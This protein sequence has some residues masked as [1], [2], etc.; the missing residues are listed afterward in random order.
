MGCGG[1]E[2]RVRPVHGQERRNSAGRL[3]KVLWFNVSC[4]EAF[5]ARGQ[6]TC[7]LI[8]GCTKA[9]MT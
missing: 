4:V 7:I 3:I 9:S 6:Y 5:L 2:S 1:A 8:Y